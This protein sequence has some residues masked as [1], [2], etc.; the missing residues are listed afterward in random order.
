MSVVSKNRI[1]KYLVR[2]GHTKN[3]AC[4]LLITQASKQPKVMLGW[5][6]YSIY[7]IMQLATIFAS[8]LE[9]GL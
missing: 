9:T 6:C 1:N 8:I 5:Q 2:V 3:G 4:E 7:I